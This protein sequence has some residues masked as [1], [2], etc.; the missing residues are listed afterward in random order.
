M[1]DAVRLARLLQR[2]GEQIAFLRAR[3]DEDRTW[4]RNDEV[5]LS[6]TKYR[7]VTAI[8][9]VLDVA[10]HILASEL[11]GPPADSG[12]AV[13]LLGGH[14]VISTELA[15]RLA[16]ATGLR[17]VLVHGYADVDDDIVVRSLA[18]IGDLAAYID[19]VR[20]WAAAQPR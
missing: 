7:F 9:A 17:N 2:L 12:D 4:L 18:D 19:Q 14:D 6:A 13:R 11:W 3:A 15:E 20:R 8:E 10:H 1:V 16:R 5:A